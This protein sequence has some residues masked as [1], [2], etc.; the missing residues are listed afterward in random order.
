MP[1]ISIFKKDLESLLGGDRSAACAISIEQLE[2]W[3]MLVKGELKG[4]HSESGEV[5]I[6]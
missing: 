6:E 1:T 4:H 5:R 3:L 2:E